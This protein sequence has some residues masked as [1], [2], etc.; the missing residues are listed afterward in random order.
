MEQAAEVTAAN[1]ISAFFPA[2]KLGM[3]VTSTIFSKSQRFILRPIL[4]HRFAH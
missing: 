4:I 3:A 2:E 1:P